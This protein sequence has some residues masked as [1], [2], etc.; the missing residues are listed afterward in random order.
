MLLV[1]NICPGP[2]IT[3]NWEQ[4]CLNLSDSPANRDNISATYFNLYLLMCHRQGVVQTHHSSW[5]KK[6]PWH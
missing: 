6:S 5:A 4:G 3:L 1:L 2:P